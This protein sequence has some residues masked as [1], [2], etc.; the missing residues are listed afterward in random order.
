MALLMPL[1]ATA[2]FVGAGPPAWTLRRAQSRALFRVLRT[3]RVTSAAVVGQNHV[4]CT[5]VGGGGERLKAI[6]FRAA[7]TDLG[8]E[9]LAG[10]GRTFHVAGSLR[11]D[12]WGGPDAVQLFIEDAA[13]V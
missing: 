4:R 7:G 1:A 2:E 5:L 10:Q 11:K 8:R 13:P 12:D 6:A 9:L 3:V